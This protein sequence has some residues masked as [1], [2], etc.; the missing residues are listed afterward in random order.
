M[1][2]TQSLLRSFRTL[3]KKRLA[4]KAM[5]RRV[6]AEERR[7]MEVMSRMLAGSG[8]RVVPVDGFKVESEHRPRRRQRRARKDLTCPKCGRR[9]FFEMHLAR[10]TNAVHGA[11]K[12]AG[13]KKVA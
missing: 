4:L 6:D 7:V 9:F 12:R 10:H 1:A 3:R 2:R 13:K 8:Y 5:G 11:K